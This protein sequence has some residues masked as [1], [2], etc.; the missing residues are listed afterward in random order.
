MGK[1][2]AIGA[3]FR[4]LRFRSGAGGDQKGGNRNRSGMFGGKRKGEHRRGN[5]EKSQRGSGVANA[6][7]ASEHHRQ[8]LHVKVP[9]KRERKSAAKEKKSAERAKRDAGKERKRKEK[10]RA[11]AAAT[12]RRK[13]DKEKRKAEK[14]VV[15][16][17]RAEEERRKRATAMVLVPD[18]SLTGAEGGGSLED[19]RGHNKK[20][21][22]RPSVR[23]LGRRV[24]RLLGK[25]PNGRGG[26]EGGGKDAREYRARLLDRL[27]R[28][29]D[30]QHADLRHR[31]K[32][33]DLE[34]DDATLYRYFSGHFSYSLCLSS[35]RFVVVVVIFAATAAAADIDRLTTMSCR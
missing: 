14:E 12:A 5:G 25:K 8:Q 11:K 28:I 16:S 31:A 17:Q 9:T 27:R 29:L 32:A 23:A 30:A 19:R 34:L 33:V 22:A 2:Q 4:K 1:R 35:V 18:K 21:R 20:K 3:F 26:D 24:A 15:L 7:N 6:E 10:S 13:A